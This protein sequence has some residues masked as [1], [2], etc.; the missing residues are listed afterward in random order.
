LDKPANITTTETKLTRKRERKPKLS[1]AERHKRFLETAR[2]VEAS[3]DPK[4]FDKAFDKVVSPPKC[5]SR[6]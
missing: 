1:D 5:S 6:D 2:E 3:D 4:D